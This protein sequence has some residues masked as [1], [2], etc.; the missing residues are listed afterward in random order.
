MRRG[1]VGEEELREV[2]AEVEG[3]LVP[4]GTGSWFHCVVTGSAL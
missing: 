3:G 1:A 4:A 2:G